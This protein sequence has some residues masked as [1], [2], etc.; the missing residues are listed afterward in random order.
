MLRRHIGLHNQ[1]W[2]VDV[3]RQYRA[4]RTR[5]RE[6]RVIGHAQITLE[7]DYV[8]RVAHAGNL[9]RL[10]A[11]QYDVKDRFNMLGLANA[12]GVASA[13]GAAFAINAL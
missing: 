2:L 7:P 6:R 10:T 5:L 4:M 9:Y 11:F 12:R 13:L 3:Q 8:Y 1:A